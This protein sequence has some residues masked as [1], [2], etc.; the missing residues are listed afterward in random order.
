MIFPRSAGIFLHPTSLPS[1]FGIGDLGDDAVRF[2]DMI[3]SIGHRFW[4][5]CPL[6]PA[7]DGNSPYQSPS[8]FAGNTLLLSPQR[9]A[10]IGLLTQD[11]LDK[12]RMASTTCVDF[13]T[14]IS[15]K[16]RLF[17]QA[18][19]RF[20][21]SSGFYSFCQQQRSWL[22]DYAL[23]MV[24]KEIHGGAAWFDWEEPMRMRDAKALAGV[25]TDNDRR[26]TYYKFLQF[27]F[28]SQWLALRAH[29]NSRNI[30]I[31]GDIPIYVAYDSVDV[32]TSPEL[33]ELDEKRTPARV[34]GV[35]PDYF[36]T[37]GQRWGNPLYRWD[38][39]ADTGYEWW[40]HRLQRTL[41]LVDCLRID[42][43]RAFES[44][45]AIDA[46]C[47]TAIKGA[48]VRGPGIE[49]FKA[50]TDALGELPI[51]A[52]DLGDITPAVILLRNESGYPGMKVLQFGFDGNPRNPHL[53]YFAVPHS[54]VYT[55]THDNDTVINWFDNLG[56]EDALRV[57]DYLG[58][59][60]TALGDAMLRLAYSCAS[61][62]CIVPLQDALGLGA[63][64]RFNI[65]GTPS[66]NWSWRF[67]W[68][69]IDEQS[70][71]RLRLFVRIYGR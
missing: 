36:A 2:V 27:Q 38:H 14:V 56:K 49:F 62:L 25:V 42:H 17:K 63:H 67:S 22:D 60:K 54:V 7:G 45:W 64:S 16:N 48:W 68:D 26:I 39:M 66:G 15:V 61:N 1:P 50:C 10:N 30:R 8:S 19:D 55:G 21:P 12:C 52:E 6:G 40:V 70:L 18:F 31:I 23:F 20:S 35:P 71:E 43:F 37:T 58:C 11:E 5:I 33:F 57:L 24:I 13:A 47:P 44:Y 4:Q 41:A 51:I 28:Y 9:L 65:P 59:D 34:A 53:S 29:A 32:W 46:E 69:M 3:A